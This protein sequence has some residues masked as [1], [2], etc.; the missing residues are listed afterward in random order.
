MPSDISPQAACIA[1]RERFVSNA[2]EIANN[3]QDA[4]LADKTEIK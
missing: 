1:Q 3:L 2:R 4:V